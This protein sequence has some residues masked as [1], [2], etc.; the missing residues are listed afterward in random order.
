MMF[1]D[2]LL[3]NG[4]SAAAGLLE[5]MALTNPGAIHKISQE[6]RQEDGEQTRRM[7]ATIVANAFVFHESLA[8]GVGDLAAVRSL[9]ELRSQGLTKSVILAEWRKILKVNYWPIFD[10][11]RQNTRSD[12]GRQ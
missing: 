7:A 12:S 11:A 1:S 5:Q 10:I 3:V 4:V 9:E 2:R 8:G 6:L